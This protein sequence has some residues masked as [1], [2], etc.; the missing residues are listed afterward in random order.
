MERQTMTTPF[1]SS[2]ERDQQLRRILLWMAV[3]RR[4][5]GLAGSRP[6]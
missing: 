1:D 5:S 6:C 4:H 2:G 3:P